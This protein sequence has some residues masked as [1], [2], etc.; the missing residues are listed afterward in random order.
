MTWNIFGG[1]IREIPLPHKRLFNKNNINV[2]TKEKRV[3]YVT[4]STFKGFV[5][6]AIHYYVSLDE[7]DN[8]I[9]IIDEGKVK[10]CLCW[11][12]EDGK[13]KKLERRFASK[14][15][16]KKWVREIFE[17]EFTDHILKERD[18]DTL[19][20]ISPKWFYKNDGD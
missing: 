4:F 8:P 18:Y 17:K 19:E 14:A 9:K 20:P 16:A 1:Y 7:E 6:G 5:E 3:V 10:W 15:A 11:D 13:G 12:D 2:L